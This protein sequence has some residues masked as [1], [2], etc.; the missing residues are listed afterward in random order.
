MDSINT[1]KMEVKLFSKW[2]CAVDVPQ[3]WA[4]RYITLTPVTLPHTSGKCFGK[5]F[6][7]SKMNIVERLVNKMM[8]AGQGSK[9]VAGK[10]IRGRGNTGKKQKALM[11]IE[12]AFDIVEK[13][14]KQN[15]LQVFVNAII[16]AGPREETTTIIYGGI[17]YHKAVDVSAQRR[18]DF[19]LKY[20]SLGAFATSFKTKKRIEECL[21]DEIVWAANSDTKSY[22]IQ[23]KEE[24]ERISQSAR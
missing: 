12:K 5:Q 11:I 19:A 3:A 14:T 10:Y 16:N 13:R 24:T 1:V 4:K 9:K 8:R 18:V 20:I 22:T 2:D 17:R 6:G 21:A 7:K 23:R 15:P